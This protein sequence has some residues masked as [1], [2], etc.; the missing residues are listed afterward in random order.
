MSASKIEAR[1]IES[2]QRLAAQLDHAYNPQL[3]EGAKR[4]VG[5]A[6]LV[7]DMNEAQAPDHSRMNYISN[8]R[9]PDMLSALK[10][11]VANLEGRMQDRPG[12]MQ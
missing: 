6:L 1:Y 2:M 5:F 3:K 8:A 7:F 9:R 4:T 11:L 10:E 12:S